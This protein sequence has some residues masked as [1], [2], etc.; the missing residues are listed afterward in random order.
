GPTSQYSK[1]REREINMHL[2]RMVRDQSEREGGEALEPAETE[3]SH[4]AHD[5][6]GRG[7]H[8]Q[9]DGYRGDRRHRSPGKHIA[10]ARAH[11]RGQHHNRGHHH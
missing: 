9:N 4:F 8:Q 10:P 7:R 2:A 3:Y 5:T 1:D 11:N 6:S